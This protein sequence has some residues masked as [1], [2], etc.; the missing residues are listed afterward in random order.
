[1]TPSP[2]CADL[3][4]QFEDCKLSAYLCPA[5]IPTI[6]WGSTGPDI[7]LGLR[8]TRAQADMRLAADLATFGKQVAALI[9]DSPT[10]QH[11]FDALCSFAYNLGAGALGKSTLL[12][13]HKDGLYQAAQGQFGLWT[14]GGGK[15]LAGLVKRRAAEAALYGRKI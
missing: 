15:V 12:K 13:D 6:G 1:M 8:W 11:Q 7:A 4:K 14:K 9:G 10:T 2:D 3:I 5:G